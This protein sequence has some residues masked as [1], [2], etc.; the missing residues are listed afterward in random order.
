[1]N[2][3]DTIYHIAY[4]TVWENALTEGQYDGGTLESEGFIHFS[5]S[6]QV[7]ATANRYYRGKTDLVLLQVAVKKLSAKLKYD[8]SPS[9]E[10]FPHLY[11]ALNLD[12]VENVYSFLPES[13]G[14]FKM[15]PA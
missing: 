6:E 12:A 1:M 7:I 2:P 9:G 15:F 14:F 3:T 13:D 5:Q 4:S 8:P 10:I 11:G